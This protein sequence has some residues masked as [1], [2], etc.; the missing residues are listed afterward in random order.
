MDGFRYTLKI[1]TDSLWWETTYISHTHPLLIAK[2]DSQDSNLIIYKKA[3]YSQESLS[4]EWVQTT[5]K[6][7]SMLA[8]FIV[9]YSECYMHPE[10]LMYI[11][12]CAKIFQNKSYHCL[13]FLYHMFLTYTHKSK[14]TA[15]EL[16]LSQFLG[17]SFSVFF[18]AYLYPPSAM[19]CAALPCTD[20]VVSQITPWS[21]LCTLAS[22]LDLGPDLFGPG[23][24]SQVVMFGWLCCFLFRKSLPLSHPGLSTQIYF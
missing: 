15:K 2:P 11:S 22:S 3:L 17:V 20:T 12:V 21:W 14:I 16:I 8:W 9:S 1:K 19:F 13:N 23:S 5:I 18:Y 10:K 4:V 7:Q 6:F 24:S